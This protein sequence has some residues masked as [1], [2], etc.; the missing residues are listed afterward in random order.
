VTIL[1]SQRL[2]IYSPVDCCIN[3]STSLTPISDLSRNQVAKQV[4]GFWRPV[5]V[6]AS[7]TREEVLAAGFASAGAFHG[8]QLH[9]EGP[10][11]A[12]RA[13]LV[14]TLLPQALAARAAR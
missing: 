13:V 4:L 14:P 5:M 7:A 9:A 3:G 10:D 8:W 12:C 11:A 1:R 2:Q 6:V